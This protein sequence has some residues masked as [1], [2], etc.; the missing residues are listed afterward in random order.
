MNKFSL[1]FQDSLLEEK[2]QESQ[3]PQILHS[4][5]INTIIPIMSQAF[6]AVYWMIKNQIVLSIV[7]IILTIVYTF[8]F[9]KVVIRQQWFKIIDTLVLS[10]SLQAS[11]MQFIPLWIQNLTDSE[12]IWIE[13]IAIQMGLHM[14]IT[15]N[16]VQNAI[17]YAIFITA[18]IYFRSITEFNPMCLIF[19]LFTILTCYNEYQRIKGLRYQFLWKEKNLNQYFIFD[20]LIKE[21]LVILNYND[22]WDKFK[23]VYANKQFYSEYHQNPLDFFKETQISLQKMSTLT[24]L[25]YKIQD[26]KSSFQIEAFWKNKNQHLFIECR[27]YSIMDTQIILKITTKKAYTENNMYPL[28]YKGI[29]KKLKKIDRQHYHTE[30]LKNLLAA[31]LVKPKSIVNFKMQCINYNKL[32]G[33]LMNILRDNS[34]LFSLSLKSEVFY[35]NIPLL[36]IL[37]ISISKY[38]KVSTFSVNQL[39]ESILEIIVK[40]PI[41]KNTEQNQQL[42]KKL[43]GII[44]D[45]IGIEQIRIENNYFMCK[46]MN[47]ENPF[48]STMN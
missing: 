28:L 41:K 23:V 32:S 6:Q 13:D 2:Y 10:F 3:R 47:M 42:F 36:Y 11:I 5:K 27:K 33:L 37:M 45:F 14:N 38:Y 16:L 24:F 40:G 25:H 1:V 46:I 31:L 44:V 35:T 34:A 18:R 26:L 21:S 43:M 39:N 9:Y 4:F 20:D 7:Y 22:V 19:L 30:S 15:Q 29:L 48:I 12:I 17:L 8:F